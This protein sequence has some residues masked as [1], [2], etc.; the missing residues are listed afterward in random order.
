MTRKSRLYSSLSLIISLAL[1]LQLVLPGI[2]LLQ[3]AA[4]AAAPLAQ[5]TA[6]LPA[7]PTDTA[8][9]TPT[10]P[11]VLHPLE[12]ARAQSTYQAEGTAVITYTLRNILPPTIR[13]NAAPGDTITDTLDAISATNFAA[14]PNTVRGASLSLQLTNAQTGL[15]AASLPADQNGSSLAFNLGDIAPLSAANLVLTMTI[16]SA[17]AVFVDLDTGAAAYGSWRGRGVSAASGPIRLAPD[18]FAQWL[19]CTPDANCA[20]TYVTRQAAELGNDPTAIFEFVRGLDYESYP[21]SLRG[22]R[23]TLWSAAGNGVDQASLLIAL[24]RA[25]GVPAAYRLG[26]LDQTDAQTLIASMFP[27][28]AAPSG[29]ILPGSPT[30]DPA[31]D[32]ALIAEAQSHAWVEAYL[33]GSGWTPLD[34]S[35]AVAQP[36]DVFATPGGGQLAELP[37]NLRHK[38]TANLVVEKYSA[39]P[40]GGTNLYTVEPLTATFNTVALAGEPLVFAHL[41]DSNYQGGLAFSSAEHTYTPYFIVGQAET[42]VEGEAFGEVISNF[43]FGQDM[44]VAE[45]LDFTLTA[46]DG[47]SETYRRELFD[48][49]GYA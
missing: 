46:P 28:V 10:E 47:R 42:L 15:Q 38:V 39:F 30:A 11:D 37:D 45:W 22:A 26:A 8:V 49:I 27:E 40:V 17:T 29:L 21:G 24:L 2:G 36:G 32:P 48:D 41:V 4:I 3:P 43:P 9:S 7:L 14:D 19:V 5:D 23:G 25:S 44:V 16:P 31:N 18:G 12:L 1:L 6:P 33:P 34:P 35:F 13:P 20:D